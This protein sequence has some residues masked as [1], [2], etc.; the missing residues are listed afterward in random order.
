MWLPKTDMEE[1]LEEVATPPLFMKA[2]SLLMKQRAKL[3][4][5]AGED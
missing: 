2:K 1:S 3:P 5:P 4:A